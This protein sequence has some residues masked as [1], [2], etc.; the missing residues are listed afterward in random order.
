MKKHVGLA[1]G[2]LVII[3][4]ASALYFALQNKPSSPKSIELPKGPQTYSIQSA[5]ASSN[6]YEATIDPLDVKPGNTQKMIVKVRVVEHPI[7]SVIANVETDSGIKTYNLQ[8]STGNLEDGVWQGE[9]VVHDTHSATY[10]TTFV[11]TNSNGETQEVTL[12]WTDPCAPPMNGD[13]TLDGN[14]AFTGV[15]GVEQGNVVINNSAFTMTISA[16]ATFVWNPGK[17]VQITAGSIAINQTGQMKQG[18]LCIGDYDQDYYPQFRDGILWQRASNSSSC[19]DFGGSISGIYRRASSYW[20][21]PDCYDNNSSAR[22]GQTNYFSSSRGDGS[23]DYN[24]DGLETK[25]FSETNEVSS[26]T[27]TYNATTKSGGWISGVPECGVSTSWRDCRNYSDSS[28]ANLT[29]EGD[30]C[31]GTRFITT[32]DSNKTQACK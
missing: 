28:C 20:T 7:E 1:I 5:K 27:C 25:G 17:S 10:R 6:I 21:A 30:S 8:L 19:S 32:Y 15:N 12:T 14:C 23:F 9:W 3:G 2:V 16:D 22:P 13:W 29:E 18:Y 11:A 26:L 31:Y 4:G 24:C